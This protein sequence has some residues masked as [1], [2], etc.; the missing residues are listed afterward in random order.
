MS[1]QLLTNLPSLVQSL[2]N[3]ERQIILDAYQARGVEA[4]TIDALTEQAIQAKAQ[5]YA[6]AIHTWLTEYGTVSTEVSTTINTTHPSG[7]IV[8][9]GTALTQTNPAPVVGTGSGTGTGIGKIS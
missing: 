5:G 7:S 3:V 2:A 9:T 4:V 1:G 8:V 6:E